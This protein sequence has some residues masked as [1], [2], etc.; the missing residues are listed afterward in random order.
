MS[1]TAPCV[2]LAPATYDGNL[3][4]MVYPE[5]AYELLPDIVREAMKDDSDFD[6]TD[7]GRIFQFT[8]LDRADIVVIPSFGWDGGMGMS[9]Y[10]VFYVNCRELSSVTL[11]GGPIAELVEKTDKSEPAYVVI[12]YDVDDKQIGVVVGF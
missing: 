11:G 4:K 6:G 7:E 1:Q 9:I 10:P 12:K 2:D 5:V 3:G 8:V